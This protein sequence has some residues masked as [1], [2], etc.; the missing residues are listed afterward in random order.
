M[1]NRELNRLPLFLIFVDDYSRVMWLHLLKSKAEVPQIT[2]QFCNLIFNEFGKRVKHF[3]TDNGT[4]FINAE[5]RSYFLD[6]GI[7]HESSCVNTPQQ[8]GLAERRMGYILG[9][10][11]SLLFQ[12]NLSKKYWGEA[13]LIATHLIN[14]IPMKIID[15][16]SPLG[17][18]K[19]SFPQVRLFT[20]LPARV[21][22]CVVYVHQDAGKLDPRGLRCVF[23]G[24]SG[25]QKGYRCYHP[26]S[27][28]FF[29]SANVIF[30][31]SEYYYTSAVQPGT[32]PAETEQTEFEFLRYVGGIPLENQATPLESETESSSA[33]TPAEAQPNQSLAEEEQEPEIDNNQNS[34][35]MEEDVTTTISGSQTKTIDD[36]LSWPIALRKGIRACRT[37]VRHPIGHYARYEKLGNEYKTFLTL[38]GDITIPNRVEEALQDPR[39]KA[40]MDEEMMAL[41]KN[42]T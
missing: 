16:E 38:L 3:R 11:R 30:N 23:I 32:A 28:K 34:A 8:N 31:E 6:N 27:R 25:M 9:T 21:F 13:I 20:G 10:A 14:Q 4:E 41:E 42:N 24:Y 26:P 37:N 18:L 35:E 15:Y 5:V 17:R 19:K 33:M 40:A 2:V 1:P 39:W 22:G 29:V 36:D 12:G 7:L